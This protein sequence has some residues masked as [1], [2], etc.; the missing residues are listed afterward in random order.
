MMR[1]PFIA[2][3]WKMNLGIAESK[4]LTEALAL[5]TKD[6]R[7]VDIAVAPTELCLSTVVSSLKDTGIHVA[8]QN[9]HPMT[10]GAYTGEVSPTMLREAGVAY[11]LVGHSERRTLFGE[12]NFD[13][14]QKVVAAFEAGLLPILCL[15]ETLQ[16]RESGSAEQVV[17]EQL[18]S[19][20]ET[21][22]PSQVAA[23][24]IAYEPVWAIGTGKTA[25]PQEAQ[26][27]HAFIRSLLRDRYPS[28]VAEDVRIQYGGSVKP[29]NAKELLSQPDID[30]AL[31]GG[32]S[33]S[34]ES[35]VGILT[36]I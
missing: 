6:I 24:T 10:K 28:F 30:G 29:H 21:L 26:Q 8:S 7:S 9:H 33:L 35:F 17:Q 31:V 20:L 5:A 1:R 32:A 3:N 15:G 25:S 22:D 19:A 13:V 4:A 14:K 27:M 18:L 34:V 36:A 2:G 12:T 16:E 11:A 23:I